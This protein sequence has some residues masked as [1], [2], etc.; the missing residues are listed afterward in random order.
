[1]S[2]ETV[3]PRIADNPATASRQWGISREDVLEEC[4]R[5]VLHAMRQE[6][7]NRLDSVTGLTLAEAER[8]TGLSR[9]VIRKHAPTYTAGARNERV[10]L[11]DLKTALAKIKK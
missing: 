7:F 4:S 2:K 3:L 9:H 5:T 8:L 11:A 6:G 10:T 1:M